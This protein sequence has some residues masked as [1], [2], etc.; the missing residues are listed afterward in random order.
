MGMRCGRRLLLRRKHGRLLGSARGRPRGNVALE[1][2]EGVDGIGWVQ[3]ISKLY[4]YDRN[5]VVPGTGISKLFQSPQALR[6]WAFTITCSFYSLER[7]CL[8]VH[9]HLV[10]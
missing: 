5:Y 9:M 3:A 10:C 7:S 4:H 1:R 8:N 2:E 6:A